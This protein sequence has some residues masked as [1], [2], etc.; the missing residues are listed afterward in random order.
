M[1]TDGRLRLVVGALFVHGAALRFG[2][3]KAPKVSFSGQFVHIFV[4]IIYK[5][6]VFNVYCGADGR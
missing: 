3:K 2:H 1:Q 4:Y 6:L 5:T